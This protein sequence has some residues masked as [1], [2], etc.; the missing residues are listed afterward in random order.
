MTLLLRRPLR[1]LSY[2]FH[3]NCKNFSSKVPADE[4]KLGIVDD[5]SS[6]DRSEIL[7][8]QRGTSHNRFGRSAFAASS[9]YSFYWL[10][11]NLDF[12]PTVN[13]SPVENLHIDPILPMAGLF[14]A[15][16]I[17]AAAVAYPM[18]SIHSLSWQPSTNSLGISTFRPWMT[19]G[20]QKT[21]PVGEW[22]LDASSK[23]AQHILYDLDGDFPR[24]RG[25]VFLSPSVP[26]TTLPFLLTVREETDV[27]EPDLLLQALVHPKSLQ[28]ISKPRRNKQLRKK[29]RK[30]KRR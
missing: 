5:N 22:T 8:Y 3:S 17:Q 30:V 12:V 4:E 26:R 21:I 25:H 10:W 2:P 29:K 16:V 14:T 19:P 9:F 1:R 7:L 18:R 20:T 11:Y 13:A 23:E 15:V 28:R 27:L 24:F 6:S